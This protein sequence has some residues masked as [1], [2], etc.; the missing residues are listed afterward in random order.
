MDVRPGFLGASALGAALVLV[1]A[2]SGACG[3]T[4]PPEVAVYGDSLAKEALP[5]FTS[6]TS[7][8]DRATVVD[9]VAPGAAPCNFMSQMLG[10]ARDGA[11]SA[12]VLEF[13]GNAFGCMSYA[14]G[15]TAYYDAYRQQVTDAARAFSA[16][17]VHTFLIGY[18]VTYGDVEQRDRSWGRL[19]EIY[20][21][22]ASQVPRVT[23]V[24][25]GPSVEEDQQFV[26]TLPCLASE[27]HCGPDGRNI[28]R[29]TDG[30]HFC[31]G[32]AS[33]A[34]TCET[35][36]SGALRYGKAMAAAV[37]RFIGSRSAPTYEGPPL[38]PPGAPPTVAA[39]QTDPYAT[40]RAG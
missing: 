6:L 24:N 8:G 27:P 36:S 39:G 9:H 13:S 33:D 16:A 25:A 12:A 14:L 15:S 20:A 5:Y 28:V 37:S 35:W 30:V 23:F 22:I 11:L 1:A 34:G 3:S 4:S 38:P 21:T 26:W 40:L 7:T 17:G 2:S 19:N 31:P 18:P 29:A 32:T 10:D